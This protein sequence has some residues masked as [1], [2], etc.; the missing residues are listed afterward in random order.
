MGPP[1]VPPARLAPPARPHP[2]TPPPP[3]LFEMCRHRL[4]ERRRVDMRIAREEETALSPEF[5]RRIERCQSRAV[6]EASFNPE[7]SRKLIFM[8]AR[9]MRFVGPVQH[10]ETLLGQLEVETWHA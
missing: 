1:S 7:F 10:A 9:M 8:L 4:H 2:P 6:H 5:N 3:R